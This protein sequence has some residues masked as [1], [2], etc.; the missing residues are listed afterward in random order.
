[1]KK[2]FLIGIVIGATFLTGCGEPVST[3]E[4]M[5]KIVYSKD[6]NTNL[7]FASYAFGSRNGTLT[8]VPCTPEVENL[9][10]K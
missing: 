1:M 3:K 8:Y 6:R 9:I 10:K 4:K 2:L 5:D 7:C